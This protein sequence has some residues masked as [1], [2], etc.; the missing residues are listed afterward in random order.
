M[1]TLSVMLAS[2][3]TLA[4]TPSAT[5]SEILASA[6]VPRAM[7]ASSVSLA[8]PTHPSPRILLT[9]RLPDP[10]SYEEA[11]IICGNCIAHT[12]KDRD[13]FCAKNVGADSNKCTE[14]IRGRKGLKGGGCQPLELDAL[15]CRAQYNAFINA[16]RDARINRCDKGLY[17]S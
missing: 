12:T 6:T 7:L 5:S 14:C 2:L 8:Q 3:V 4:M 13:N 10:D 16:R 1:L 11:A 15:R 9:L 17:S